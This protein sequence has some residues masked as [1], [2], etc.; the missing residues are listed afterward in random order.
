MTH[1]LGGSNVSFGLGDTPRVRLAGP[2]GCNKVF[3]LSSTVINVCEIPLSC[4][5]KPGIST[6]LARRLEE[7][8]LF[9]DDLLFSI[10]E[11]KLKQLLRSI[12]LAFPLAGREA[13]GVISSSRW[14]A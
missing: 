14:M 9:F 13:P 11:G 2:I 3:P 1:H 5:I 8:G 7:S 12:C 4:R 10:C 6:L